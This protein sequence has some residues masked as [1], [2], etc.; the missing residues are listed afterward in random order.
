MNLRKGH[1]PRGSSQDRR[2]RKTWLMAMFGD[3]DTAPCTHC[4]RTL[5]FN[6]IEV[7]RIAPGGSYARS[8]IQPS[9]GPCNR[10]R[11]DSPITPYR[12]AHA[13]EAK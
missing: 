5:T 7:D 12:P 13:G 6:T 8:N 3:G 9:C 10:N 11:G 1:D 4:R 2:R